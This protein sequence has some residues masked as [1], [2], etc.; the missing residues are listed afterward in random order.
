M[1]VEVQQVVHVERT[2]CRHLLNCVVPAYVEL[3]V[4]VSELPV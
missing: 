2:S 1:T 3:V 4:R